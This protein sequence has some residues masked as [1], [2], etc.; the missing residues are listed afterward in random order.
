MKKTIRLENILL[1]NRKMKTQRE[2]MR[3]RTFIIGLQNILL[4]NK[5]MKT[6]TKKNDRK[7]KT[8]IIKKHSIIQ[9][10]DENTKRMT[11]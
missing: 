5:E 2:R 9:Q 7:R 4:L 8:S 1:L 3:K 6:Q 11:E 10:K